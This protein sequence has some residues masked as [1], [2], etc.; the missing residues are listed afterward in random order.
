M[1]NSDMREGRK[2]GASSPNVTLASLM[3]V[4]SSHISDIGGSTKK[5]PTAKANEVT[6]TQQPAI[7]GK[8]C[9]CDHILFFLVVPTN[10]TSNIIFL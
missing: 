2:G 5:P 7:T 10:S 1:G 8:V 9:C 6:A 3:D 4:N